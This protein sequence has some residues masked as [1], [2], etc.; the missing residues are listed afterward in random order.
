M[1][2]ILTETLPAVECAPW[3]TKGDGHA[4]EVHPVDQVCMSHP[5]SVKLAVMPLVTYADPKG[6]PVREF[7]DRD[8]VNAYLL[9]E[10]NARSATIELGHTDSHVA[11][12]T[13][14][15]E[16]EYARHL[17]QLAMAALATEV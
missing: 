9:R 15:E 3:C 8:S 1:T 2:A 6:L 17:T 12:L 10:H 14:V 16:L 11:S 13:P 5:Q 7:R 4:D